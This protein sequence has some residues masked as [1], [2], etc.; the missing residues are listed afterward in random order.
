MIEDKLSRDERIRLEALALATAQAAARPG[1]M[2]PDTSAMIER[3]VRYED[4]IH[5]GAPRPEDDT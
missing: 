1:S 3:A 4:Y 2:M 5:N